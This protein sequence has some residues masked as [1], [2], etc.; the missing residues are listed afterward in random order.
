MKAVLPLSLT[1]TAIVLTACGGGGG[2][3]VPQTRASAAP[4]MTQ[5][6]IT[7]DNPSATTSAAVRRRPAYLSQATQ[8]ITISINGGTP[9]AQNLT[10]SGGNCSTPSFG[11]TPVCTLVAS[12]PVG[13]DTFT[14]VTYD[15]TNGTGNVLSRNTIVQTITAGI[16]NTVAVTLQGVPVGMLAYPYPGQANVI[17]TASGYTLTGTTVA[18][19]FV[20]STDADKNVIIGPGAP[21]LT[22]TSS[23]GNMKVATVANNPNEFV[24]TP[25]S[26]NVTVSL[27]VGATGGNGGTASAAVALTLKAVPPTSLPKTLYVFD[28][29]A[30]SPNGEIDIYPAGSVNTSTPTA[31]L[32]SVLLDNVGT[33]L[34]WAPGGNL[35]ATGNED[36]GQLVVE[37][38]AAQL[39]AGSGT[40]TTVAYSYY[41]GLPNNP[42]TKDPLFI[43]SLAVDS[44][45]DMFVVGE[46]DGG[47]PAVF[48]YPAGFTLATN[49][50]QI[51]SSPT[52][53]TA[54]TLV[55]VDS[56][57]NLYVVNAPS[58][59]TASILV[60]SAS[61]PSTAPTRTIGA[62]SGSHAGFQTV[63]GLAAGSDGT[64]T[65]MDGSTFEFYVFAPGAAN[66]PT[67]EYANQSP[68]QFFSSPMTVD[69]N[70]NG[71]GLQT[72]IG[73]PSSYQ[74]NAYPAGSTGV[75]TALFDVLVGATQPNFMIFA[76]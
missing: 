41:H 42:Q 58:E 43:G 13:S 44:K 33:A 68:A 37:Y 65:V 62:N 55:Y 11:A 31:R 22:V 74:I 20:A 64:L 25:Q 67:P 69:A 30:L 9:V 18:D 10:P 3:S 4:L 76:P 7:I 49:P 72:N 27:N 38:T 59:Q 8:S 2:S 19:F 26:E 6:T 51:P 16:A 24:L 29:E 66:N 52:G 48:E 57:D 53:E 21:T 46:L 14:F 47:T 50:T 15:G 34:A 73:D 28:Q 1:M 32:N 45:G 17:P 71:Y 12:A 63:A 54:P 75:A 36:N 39:A 5:V 23:S 56:S 40:P 70:N 60:F 35:Y 61:S